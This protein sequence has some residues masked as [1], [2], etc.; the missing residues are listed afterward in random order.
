[1]SY[2][3][4]LWASPG[5]VTAVR[6]GEIYHQL[7]DGDQTGTTADVRLLEFTAALVMRYPRLEDLSDLDASPWNMSPDA[8]DHRKHSA[9]L[10]GVAV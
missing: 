1:M 10:R 9:G 3:L 8:T 5:P 7:A 6:A 4:Y 2:D